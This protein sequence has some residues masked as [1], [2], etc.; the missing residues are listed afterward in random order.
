MEE[1]NKKTIITTK[2]R[3]DILSIGKYIF[4]EG[5]SAN[6]VKYMIKLFEFAYS[7]NIFPEKYQPCKY[8][9]FINKG[10]RCAPFENYIFVYKIHKNDII[11][12]NVIHSK[13]LNN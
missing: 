8:K 1:I 10:Y 3:K 7:L 9:R 13:R 4:L 6:S 12:I 2:A 11:V 5:N